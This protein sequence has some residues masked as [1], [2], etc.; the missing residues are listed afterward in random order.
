MMPSTPHKIFVGKKL[1]LA[2][3]ALGLTQAEFFRRSK[4]APN[5]LHNYLRGDNYPDLL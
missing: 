3:D 4:T 5:K 1:R 2:I